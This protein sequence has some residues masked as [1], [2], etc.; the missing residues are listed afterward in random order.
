MTKR[1]LHDAIVKSLCIFSILFIPLSIFST[2]VFY[3]D[4][5][6]ERVV[7]A[8]G[9]ITHKEIVSYLSGGKLPSLRDDYVM[10]LDN[11]KTQSVSKDTYFT[12][13]VGQYLEL[14]YNGRNN[15]LSKS[16]LLIVLYFLL[17]LELLCFSPYIKRKY[18]NWLDA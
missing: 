17:F 4:D 18:I 11:K 8:K 10:V 14:S 16:D 7:Y 9:I 5:K 15:D 2:H 13:Q 3:P 1:E 12:H 6:Y